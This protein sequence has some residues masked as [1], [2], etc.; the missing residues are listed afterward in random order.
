MISEY[1]QD[2]IT[3]KWTVVSPGRALR[4]KEFV[5]KETKTSQAHRSCVFCE[6]AEPLTPKEVYAMRKA[7]TKQNS[8]GWTVRVVPN[9]FPAFFTGAKNGSKES[10]HFF[11]SR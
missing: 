11:Q 1:R 6:G 2:P 7:G 4:P 9:K 5:A 3:K 8:P 10:G